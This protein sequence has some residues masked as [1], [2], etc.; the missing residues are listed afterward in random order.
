MK[1]E[2]RIIYLRDSDGGI[3]AFDPRVFRLRLVEAF[4]ASGDEEQSY[5]SEELVLALEYTLLRSPREELI[6]NCTEID[7]VLTRMLESHG[8]PGPAKHFRSNQPRQCIRFSTDSETIADFLLSHLACSRERTI[9]IAQ[10]LSE[11][12]E[13]LNITEASPHL[14]MEF[15]RH[16]ETDFAEKDL[17]TDQ[18]YKEILTDAAKRSVSKEELTSLLPQEAQELMT[19]G[20]L[21]ING[22]TPLFPGVRFFFFMCKF[23]EMQNWESPLTEL[24]MYPALYQAG[25]LLEKCRS[26]IIA[27]LPEQEQEYP[28]CL[29]I[30]DMYEFIER[31]LGSKQPQKLAEEVASALSEPLEQRLYKISMS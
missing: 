18:L 26:A 8:F 7:A 3:T 11:A 12:L 6:F 28:C 13:K 14:I 1:P 20:I 10:T 22:I 25:N 29:A 31:Y 17:L 30:P 21:G 27:K 4:K 24:E 19:A 9:H 23:A 2:F 16:Y 15:A 5:M